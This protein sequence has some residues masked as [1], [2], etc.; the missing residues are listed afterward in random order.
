MDRND[1]IPDAIQL[2]Y[3]N[4]DRQTGEKNF[5]YRVRLTTTITPWGATRYWFVCPLLVNGRFCEEELSITL[6]P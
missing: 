3:T 4:T 1:G 2:M 5:D 6:H